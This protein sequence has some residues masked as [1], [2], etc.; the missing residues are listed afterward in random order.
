MKTI[1]TKN[2]DEILVD[3]EDFIWASWFSWYVN[4]HGYAVHTRWLRGKTH[5]VLMHR[6]MFMEIPEGMQV[7]HINGN[8]LDNRRCNLRLCTHSENMRN[9]KHQKGTS[10]KYKG[11]Y[12]N[13]LAGKWQTRI[14]VKGK[15]KHLGYFHSEEVAAWAYDMYAKLYFGKF[16][17]LNSDIYGDLSWTYPEKNYQL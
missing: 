6:M 10:S 3:D 7:D 5:G 4:S 17:L 16:A 8:K 9:R 15:L 13:K 2:G 11:V 12:W 14:K 1:Y